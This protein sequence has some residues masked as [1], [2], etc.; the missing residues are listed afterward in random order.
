MAMYA[1]HVN[2]AVMSE[3]SHLSMPQPAAVKYWNSASLSR[4]ALAKEKPKM[5]AWRMHALSNRN[6]GKMGSVS[7]MSIPFAK[8]DCEYSPSFCVMRIEPSFSRRLSY[9]IMFT[10]TTSIIEQN[11]SAN[12]RMSSARPISAPEMEMETHM[13]MPKIRNC[14]MIMRTA[15]PSRARYMHA[16]P[17]KKHSMPMISGEPHSRYAAWHRASSSESVTRSQSSRPW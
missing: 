11:R 7:V 8:L 14:T 15:L 13:P 12:C 9:P 4:L 16:S 5:R 1:V 3:K 2:T 10:H 17:K 6:A